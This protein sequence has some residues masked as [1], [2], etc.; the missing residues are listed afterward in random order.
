MNNVHEQVINF[1]DILHVY[2]I[3]CSM[4]LGKV[5]HSECNVFLVSACCRDPCLRFSAMLR[6]A[7]P[8]GA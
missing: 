4:S 8:N 2:G 6:V 5:S 1:K 3:C 7:G